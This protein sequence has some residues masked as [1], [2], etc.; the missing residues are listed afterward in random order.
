MLVYQNVKE[1]EAKFPTFIPKL[2]PFGCQDSPMELLPIDTAWLVRTQGLCYFFWVGAWWKQGWSWYGSIRID[3]FLVG[4][5]SIY[6]LFWGSLGTRV[7][8]HPH[9]MFFFRN[10]ISNIWITLWFSWEFNGC[11][12][13]HGGDPPAA[14]TASWEILELNRHL[15]GNIHKLDMFH[16]CARLPEANEFLRWDSVSFRM[17]GW[18]VWTSEFMRESSHKL[19][20]TGWSAIHFHRDLPSGKLT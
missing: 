5:T 8:T 19:P 10:L 15:N 20:M 17:F 4:W 12:H 1:L 16:S 13:Q 11:Y 18:I 7:L 2:G 9:L 3:T 14:S 6:Q